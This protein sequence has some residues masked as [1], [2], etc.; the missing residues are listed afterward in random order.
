MRVIKKHSGREATIRGYQLTPE[1]A[2][3]WLPVV[4]QSLLF[5]GLILTWERRLENV[6]R[7]EK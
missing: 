4:S 3:L 6:I 5:R 2:K 1:H 7:G